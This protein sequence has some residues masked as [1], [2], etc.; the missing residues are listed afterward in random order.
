M[1]HTNKL[2]NNIPTQKNEVIRDAIGAILRNELPHK[3]KDNGMLG[4]DTITSSL[5]P[6][7]KSE[8]PAINIVFEG[9]EPISKS[10]EGVRMNYRYAIYISSRSDDNE[11]SGIKQRDKLAGAVRYILDHPEF[12]SLGLE[13]GFT[14]T[15]GF[16]NINASQHRSIPETDYIVTTQLV[17][18]VEC[19]EINELTEPI[20]IKESLAKI[21][22]GKTEKGYR[23]EY[24]S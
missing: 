6:L 1:S 18:Q 19:E 5:I 24:F 13:P 17:F 3:S 23:Y 2:L 10:N 4:I 8:L 12:A 9:G 14:S 20:F 21:K 11:I 7:D 22:L 15:S 16:L